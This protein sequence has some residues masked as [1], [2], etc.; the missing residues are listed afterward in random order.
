MA[1]D[2]SIEK[3]TTIKNKDNSKNSIYPSIL[4]AG[5]LRSGGVEAIKGK[6]FRDA[7]K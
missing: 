3:L 1:F 4:S 5:L 6:V 7:H 2:S